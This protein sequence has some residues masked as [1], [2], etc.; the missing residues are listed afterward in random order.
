MAVATH[1]QH[2]QWSNSSS[3]DH[4]KRRNAYYPVQVTL[5]LDDR[6]DSRDDD[7]VS[8]ASTTSRARRGSAARLHRFASKVKKVLA[9]I[10]PFVTVGKG[11]VGI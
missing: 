10:H 11:L 2:R 6:A 9:M 4:Q 3:Y 7:N 1:T 5:S 8:V